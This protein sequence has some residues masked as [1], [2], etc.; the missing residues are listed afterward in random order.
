MIDA[1]ALATLPLHTY[2]DKGNTYV[3]IIFVDF[4]IQFTGGAHKKGAMYLFKL[5][6]WMSKAC[7]MEDK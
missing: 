3:R 4:D 2:L 6:D 1:I 5:F 7:H